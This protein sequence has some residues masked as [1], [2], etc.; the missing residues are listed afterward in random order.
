M[1][2]H[3]FLAEWTVTFPLDVV[4]TRI[5]GSQPTLVPTV[6]PDAQSPTPLLRQEPLELQDVNPYRTIFSTIV[7][8][9]Q[10]E[11]IQVFFK[12]LSPTLLR[13]LRITVDHLN[14]YSLFL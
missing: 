1:T 11:G 8:S 13:L 14:S 2:C 3:L 4:K 5:Q 9:Y 12:G 10:T 6:L 7:H